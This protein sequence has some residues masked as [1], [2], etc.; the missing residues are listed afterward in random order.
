LPLAETTGLALLLAST[1]VAFL[2][3][4]ESSG[5]VTVTGT[6]RTNQPVVG[7]YPDPTPEW[8]TPRPTPQPT[9]P[10]PGTLPTPAPK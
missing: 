9:L 7:V 1:A 2:A 8:Y 4:C 3:A 10:P 5:G 6:G